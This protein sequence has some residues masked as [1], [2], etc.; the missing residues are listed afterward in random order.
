MWNQRPNAPKCPRGDCAHYARKPE[1]TPCR[2]CTCNR[3]S[4]SKCKE[5]SYEPKGADPH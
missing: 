3:S 4:T 5:L 2:Y 1:E